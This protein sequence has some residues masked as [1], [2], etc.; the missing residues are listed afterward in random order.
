MMVRV[1]RDADGRLHI[2]YLKKR[3]T[4]KNYD[5]PRVPH[6]GSRYEIGPGTVPHSPCSPNLSSGNQF[7]FLKLRK[8]L[9]ELL[10]DLYET[11]RNET[12]FGRKTCVPFKKHWPTLEM[13]QIQSSWF[14]CI[15]TCW[16]QNSPYKYRLAVVLEIQRYFISRIL[17]IFILGKI[18]F[19]MLLHL[20]TV[21]I[22]VVSRL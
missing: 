11:L 9:E 1:F 7:Q 2:N 16:I 15:F 22:Q 17:H 8:W 6:V 14:F 5:Y 12:L 10:E 19:W 3:P 13:S 4:I 20:S 21:K 18:C